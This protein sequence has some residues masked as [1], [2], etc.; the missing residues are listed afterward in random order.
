MHD[1]ACSQNRMVNILNDLMN[2][3]FVD[4]NLYARV[5]SAADR[6]TRRKNGLSD[7]YLVPPPSVKFPIFSD[8]HCM[9][10]PTCNLHHQIICT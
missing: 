4:E 3:M 1:R 9:P 10:P 5:K 8:C 7:N 6:P 2:L